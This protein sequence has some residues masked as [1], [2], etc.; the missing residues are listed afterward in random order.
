MTPYKYIR[1]SRDGREAV[2]WEIE[3]GGRYITTCVVDVGL[4]LCGIKSFPCGNGDDM[5]LTPEQQLAILETVQEERRRIL[6]RYPVKTYDGWLES[7]MPT[8]EEYCFP[9]DEVDEAMVDYFVNSV[10][11][12]L[13][14]SSCTQAGEPFSSEA[15]D[16]RNCY[17]LTYTTFPREAEGRWRYDGNCFYGENTNRVCR[18]SRLEE[19]IEQA[20]REVAV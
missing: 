1:G 4:L 8:F 18:Q 5:K 13:M 9:G 19:R 15:D 16:E 6:E 3:H 14:R 11:P 7:G 17:R 12:V 2:E 20:R 10:P